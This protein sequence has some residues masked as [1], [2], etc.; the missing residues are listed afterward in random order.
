MLLADA[1]GW[2]GLF[3]EPDD[4]TFPKLRR[5]YLHNPNVATDQQANSPGNIEEVFDRHGVP[6]E[7][8]VLSIDV[9]TI[10]Y[11]IWRALNNY[12]HRLVVVEYNSSLNPDD[13]LVYPE[14]TSARWD[15]TR[16]YGSSLGAFRQLAQEKHYELVHTEMNGVNSFFVRDDLAPLV[17]VK[18]PPVRSPN[19]G[20]T[21]GEMPPDPLN[22]S[23]VDLS[24]N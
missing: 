13:A 3:C 5:K 9:D 4:D 15:E 12:R 20:F 1:Y 22:R 6:L 21:G 2:S 8:V 19:F 11:W 10:D 14:D 23:W 16:F 24:K 18:S 7:L 17:G